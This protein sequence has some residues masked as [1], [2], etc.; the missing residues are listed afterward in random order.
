MHGGLYPKADIDRFYLPREGGQGLIAVE[1][2]VSLAKAGLEF[3]GNNSKERLIKTARDEQW[4]DI[5]SS[6]GLNRNR[7]KD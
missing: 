2:C 7:K 3:Y 6:E 4:E 5:G 1:D